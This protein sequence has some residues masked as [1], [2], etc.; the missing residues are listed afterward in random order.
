M[1]N[2]TPRKRFE[3]KRGVRQ[4]DPLSPLLFVM[5]ADFL[6][7][8]VNR[9]KDL[10][11]LKL[12]IP[13]QS[14]KD[15]P[16]VQYADD[17]LIIMEGDAR[18]IFLLKTILQNFSDSTGLKVNYSKSMML[19]INMN[20]SRLDHLAKTLGCSKGTLPFTY[21]GLPLGTTKPKIADFLPLVN[22]CEK[23]LGGISTMLNQ[24]RKLQTTNVVL[25]AL[26]TY[27]MS[28]L[29][30]PKAIIKKIDKLRK[31]CLWRGS[32]VN[33]RGMAKAAWKLVCKS[34][35]QGGLGIINLEVQNQALLMKNLD[36]FYNRKDI[37][38]VNMVWEKHYP[39]DKLP[40]T[41]KKGSFWWR[42]V[43]KGLPK[44]K[45]M[46][47]VQVNI[48]LTCQFWKDKWET[49]IWR[50]KFPQAFS[51][52]KDKQIN[53]RKAF[54]IDDIINL[55]NLPLSQIAFQQIQEI[56]QRMET[57]NRNEQEQDIWTYSAQSS[58]FK[59]QKIYKLLMG[60]QPI[61]P[62]LKWL[63][64]SYCQPKHRVFFWLLMN[65]RLSIKN[66]LKRRKMQLDSFNC[67]FYGSAQ[68][69]TV[70]HL[71]WGCPYAQQCWGTKHK[72]GK[73]CK[74]FML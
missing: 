56:Q 62:A 64:K 34:K 72:M 50:N 25:S 18:Q 16:I 12:P 42:D 54:I 19:P 59:V 13:I 53:V 23:R 41:I 63:W 73:H 10:G 17:T 58:S 32:D 46:A 60:H 37:P 22:K 3:C 65:D 66:I 49:E 74:T 2:D 8:L 35:E 70:L 33:G 38:W 51:F 21:L 55:F 71:F 1:L 29:E 48:G 39:N 9:A 27:Y 26:P 28:T 57:Y 5:A 20:E 43:L 67:A 36:K 40:G 52:A 24:A 30:L 69:E 44:F 14:E 61:Q 47:R 4:G 6:Q 68:E 15:F 31:N 7:G 11:L 45:D